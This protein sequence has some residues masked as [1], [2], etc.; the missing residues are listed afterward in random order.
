MWKC[1]FPFSIFR[2]REPKQISRLGLIYQENDDL[3][4][5]KFKRMRLDLDELRR[6]F[7]IQ[8]EMIKDLT[9]KIEQIKTEHANAVLA[10]EAKNDILNDKVDTLLSDISI[11]KQE[12]NEMNDDISIFSIVQNILDQVEYKE[13]TTDSP[14]LTDVPPFDKTGE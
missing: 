2:R 5:M 1:C 9:L 14:V 13:S 10:L 12:C 3:S 4:P 7:E 11:M 8:N 6:E